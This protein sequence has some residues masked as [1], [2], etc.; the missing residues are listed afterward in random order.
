MKTFNVTSNRHDYLFFLFMVF[1]FYNITFI[2]LPI[3]SYVWTQCVLII[4]Y[5]HIR[6]KNKAKMEAAKNN[7]LYVKIFYFWLLLFFTA[8]L[9]LVKNF[10]DYGVEMFKILI[11]FF[12]ASILFPYVF[13]DLFKS[14]VKKSLKY[15]GMVG[16]TNS[17]F[18]IGMFLFP[19]IQH[20]WL[21]L[22]DYNQRDIYNVLIE[23][24]MIGINGLSVYSAAV[25]Q[26]IFA[27]CYVLHVSFRDSN[28]ILLKDFFILLSILL[29]AALTARTFFFIF[30]FFFIFHIYIFGA[31]KTI[32][33]FSL[34]FFIFI[35]FISSL[36]FFHDNSL[37]IIFKYWLFEFYDKFMETG[38]LSKNIE[39]LRK[40][41]FY[42]FS[43]LGDFK[44]KDGLSYYMY[45]DIGYQRFLFAI[46]YIGMLF[47][48]L[49][50]LT[51]FLLPKTKES[52]KI[53]SAYIAILLI[54]V[55][56]MLKGA[57]FYDAF[58]LISILFILGLYI[59]QKNTDRGEFNSKVQPRAF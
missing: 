41:S 18:I 26:V 1:Y 6:I 9:S 21:S 8:L 37:M 29:S 2:F 27:I 36:S 39:M 47:F 43:M 51:S 3:S 50:F 48:V 42:D 5:I 23:L 38:S 49:F 35:F 13:L 57:I 28:K 11:V 10:N 46:G 16:F 17:I 15:I 31:K 19:P 12:T 30:P 4:L 24:R 56:T 25:F 44:M 20:A 22:I 45:T 59:D 7:R 33:I 14:N 53:F 40:Y 52:K 55:V 58:P 32:F 54:M 34:Y